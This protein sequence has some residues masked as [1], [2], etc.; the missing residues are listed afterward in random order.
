MTP[1]PKRNDLDGDEET[2]AR[3]LIVQKR[4]SLDAAG[5]PEQT[6][7]EFQIRLALIISL[8]W[9]VVWGVMAL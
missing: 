1:N 6:K 7:W 9:L 3:L 5:Q 2:V 4:L 8:A